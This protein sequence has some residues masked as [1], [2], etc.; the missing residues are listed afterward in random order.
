M[1]RKFFVHRYDVIRVKVAVEATDHQSAMK[2]ADDYLAHN[3]PVPAEHLYTSGSDEADAERVGLPHWIHA[4][5]PGQEVTGYLVDAFGDDEHETTRSYTRSHTPIHD[6]LE[7]QDDFPK[8]DW[9]YDVANNDTHLGY[10]D[11]AEMNRANSIELPS[12]RTNLDHDALAEEIDRSAFETFRATLK[13]H[14]HELWAKITGRASTD[15]AY[16]ATVSRWFHHGDTVLLRDQI[17]APFSPGAP[18]NSREYLDHFNAF[19]HLD[20]AGMHFRESHA[21]QPIEA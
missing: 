2:A 7:D 13:D 9:R 4:E 12:D 18:V 14:A 11:W 17:C 1:M 8:S 21:A 16:R 6:P 5:E 10:C 20:S 3:H 19:A 15:T